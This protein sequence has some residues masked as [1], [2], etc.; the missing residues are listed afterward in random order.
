[1]PRF[2][3]CL[4]LFLGLCAPLWAGDFHV[5]VTGSDENPGTPEKPF[6]TIQRAA[7]LMQ[8][9]DR[10]LIHAGTYREWVRPPRGGTA[11]DKRITYQAAPGEDVVLKGSEAVTGWNQQGALWRRELDDAF[12]GER[13]PF[14]TNL[15]G[16]W[17][18]FGKENHLGEI[19]LNGAALREVFSADELARTPMSWMTEAAPGKTVLLANVEEYDP[20]SELVE[21]AVRASVFFPKIKGLQFITLEGLHFSQGASQWVEWLIYQEGLVGTYFGCRWRIENCRFTDA[22]CVALVAGNDPSYENDGFDMASVGHH[23]VR[24]NHFARCG[25][26]AIHGFKGWAGSTIEGNLIEDINP[27]RQFGG[28]ESGGIK[29]HLP[30]DVTV[31]NNIIRRVCAGR[32]E[33]Y[34]GKKPLQYTGIWMDWGGQ[35]TR[36]SGNVVYDTESWALFLQN[37]QGSPILVDH[38]IF[39]RNINVEA[40]GVVFAHNLFLK[41]PWSVRGGADV[42][43]WEP[44]SAKRV[45]VAPIPAAEVKWWNNLF[46]G[47]AHDRVPQKPGYVSDWNAFYGG[48]KKTPWGDERSLLSESAPAVTFESLPDGVEIRFSDGF[49]PPAL[50]GPVVTKEF[51]GLFPRT[52]QGLEDTEGRPINLDR[53]LLGQPREAAQLTAGP[54]QP[55]DGKLPPVR[56]RAGPRRW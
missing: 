54:V 25:E 29:I 35:G 56:L 4:L 52:N 46:F 10:C 3:L 1:M 11:E 19:F 12:F 47:Q 33:N 20:N 43:Y 14:K 32:P 27:R 53:D 18:H 31:R 21:V 44:H 38:N 36:V 7:D 28:E 41:C 51:V 50:Q 17:I 37:D 49:V 22:K 2:P 16:A 24:N 6:K 40:Q 8:P 42:S 55:K 15:G 23:L 34:A 48:A 5:A 26:A 13:N 30:I 9:G 39:E 45:G